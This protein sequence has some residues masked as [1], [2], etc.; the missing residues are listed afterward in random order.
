MSGLNQVLCALTRIVKELVDRPLEVSV[1]ATGNDF[2]I[3][4]HPDDLGKIIGR[5]GATIR[6]IRVWVA[7]CGGKLKQPLRVQ[8]VG[9]R[10]SA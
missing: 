10:R 3:D 6:A 9:D 2:V 4:V 5:R 8:L 7:A 1:M